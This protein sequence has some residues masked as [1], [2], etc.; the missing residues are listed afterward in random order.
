MQ[1]FNGWLNIYKPKNISSAH[2]INKVKRILGK[3]QKI[4][5]AGTLDPMAEG[6]LPVALGEATK[7]TGVMVDKSKTYE[8]AIQFGYK[9]DTAD[10]TGEI[11]DKSNINIEEEKLIEILQKFTGKIQQ[12]PSKYSA[13]K[14]DGQRAYKKARRGEVFDMPSREIYIHDI[15]LEEFKKQEGQA[16][17]FCNCSKGTYIRTLAEDIAFGLQTLGFVIELRRLGVGSFKIDSSISLA[18]F[19]LTK[20]EK[21]NLDE[22]KFEN[23]F[24]TLSQAILPVDFVLDDIP[25]INIGQEVA[26]KVKFGQKVLFSD[27]NNHEYQKLTALKHDSKLIATGKIIE[28]GK[29]SINRVFNL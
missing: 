4:G 12:I 27:V 1:K 9:T 24:K 19:D 23:S 10:A 17:I 29:F 20:T 15:I 25:V 28:D 6:I 5:H 21:E 18:E 13:I 16:K 26:K 2:I 7:L 14:I 22:S 11:I 8:F 3:G